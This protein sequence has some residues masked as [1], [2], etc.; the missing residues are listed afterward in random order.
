MKTKWIERCEA[1]EADAHI[2]SSWQEENKS[3]KK[4][5]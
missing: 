5:N 3:N 1:A 4:G 2:G